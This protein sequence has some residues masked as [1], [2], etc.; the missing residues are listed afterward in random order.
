M[1]DGLSPQPRC[2]HQRLRPVALGPAPE[3]EGRTPTWF[4][5]RQF[6]RG[7]L[8]ADA[9]LLQENHPVCRLLQWSPTVGGHHQRPPVLLPGC[10]KLLDLLPAFRIKPGKGFVEDKQTRIAREDGGEGRA[11]P[12]SPGEGAQRSPPL[13]RQAHPAKQL[14]RPP[15]RPAGPNPGP[16]L[17]QP[18][19][20][21][22]RCLR[23]ARWHFR[24]VTQPP[25]CPGAPGIEPV[26]AHGSPVGMHQAYG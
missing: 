5:R 6:R 16:A 11:L 3:S 18:D 4:R 9:P 24:Q 20:L 7:A 13:P 12:L 1:L 26:Q 25:A 15:L 14:V 21:A 17:T 2:G 8:P 23:I 10:E 22:H 19:Q